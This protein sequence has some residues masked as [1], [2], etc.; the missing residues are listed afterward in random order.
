MRGG[1]D[2]AAGGELNGGG[3]LVDGDGTLS[4]VEAEGP[5]SCVPKGGSG[6]RFFDGEY[7]AYCVDSVEEDSPG[8]SAFC[9]SSEGVASGL[10]YECVRSARRPIERLVVDSDGDGVLAC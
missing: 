2:V 5:P 1:I 3:A 9:C 7:T 6:V 4:L 10:S 8:S